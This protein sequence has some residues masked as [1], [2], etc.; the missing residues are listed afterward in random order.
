MLQRKSQSAEFDPDSQC[1]KLVHASQIP[2]AIGHVRQYEAPVSDWCTTEVRTNPLVATFLLTPRAFEGTQF[3]QMTCPAPRRVNVPIQVSRRSLRVYNRKWMGAGNKNAMTHDRI[4][5]IYACVRYQGAQEA[6]MRPMLTAT[7]VMAIVTVML[8][9]ALGLAAPPADAQAS[10]DLV[11]SWSLV[12]LTVS[13]SGNDVEL[14]GPHPQGQLIFNSDGRY[15]LLGVRSDLPRFASDNRQTGTPEENQRIVLGNVAHFGT[16]SVDAAAHVI[17]FHIA[18][19]TFPNW[20][21]DVQRRPYT[22]DG[23]RLTYVTPGSFGYGS[24]KVVWQRMK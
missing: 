2:G 8:S 3:S 14:L 24:A 22:V 13:R 11:G 16:Y 17:V 21:G 9:V 12:S 1:W 4:R 23:D 10:S 19:S 18:K 6:I 7:A 20:D 5:Q 15:V